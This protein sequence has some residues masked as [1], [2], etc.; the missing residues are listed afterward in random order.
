MDVI[1][2]AVSAPLM[3]EPSTIP[4]WVRGAGAGADAATAGADAG[5]AT[6][7]DAAGAAAAA[8]AEASLAGTA[9][10]AGAEAAALATGIGVEAT[11]TPVWAPACWKTSPIQIHIPIAMDRLIAIQHTPFFRKSANNW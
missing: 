1:I 6:G 4:G 9:G 3:V 5:A 8:G 2:Q 11:L 10:A 7:A